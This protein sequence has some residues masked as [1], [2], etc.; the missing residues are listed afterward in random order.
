M[1]RCGKVNN[2]TIWWPRKI[3]ETKRFKV[4][5]WR[6]FDLIILKVN[7]IHYK[8]IEVF[9]KYL[10]LNLMLPPVVTYWHDHVQTP[11]PRAPSLLGLIAMQASL[12][13]TLRSHSKVSNHLHL[14]ILMQQLVLLILDCSFSSGRFLCS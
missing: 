7:W 4:K 11:N 6:G 10:T 5:T 8:R 1:Q 12:F 9:T 13:V 2:T 3:N 14:L